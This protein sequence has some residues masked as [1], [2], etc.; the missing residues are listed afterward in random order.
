MLYNTSLKRS[1]L[2]PTQKSD[3]YIWSGYFKL[4][5]YLFWCKSDCLCYYL[6]TKLLVSPTSWFLVIFPTG[7]YVWNY[8]FLLQY[9]LLSN[10]WDFCSQDNV[11]DY[12]EVEWSNYL[13][14]A[15]AFHIFIGTQN[16]LAH[17]LQAPPTTTNPTY[18]TWLTKYYSMMTWLLNSLEEKISSSV[19]FLTTAKETWDTLNVMYDNKKNPSRLFEIYERLF[20]LKQKK[21]I[22]AWVL[23]RTQGFEWWARDASTCCYWYDNPK[24][25]SLR[26]SSTKVSIQL[27]S[28][29]TIPGAGHILGGDSNLLKSYAVST[30]ADVFSAPSIEQSVM[31]SGRDRGHGHHC[32]FGGQGRGSIGGGRGSYEGRQSTSEKG[33]RHCRHY[34]YSNHIF[35]KCWEKFGQP[36]WAQLSDSDPPATCDN[37]QISSSAISGSFMI[38][39]S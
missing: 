26:F 31:V 17:L 1:N 2:F 8:K 19:I 39:L 12:G 23:W 4:K 32:D 22:C 18:V 5:N 21:Q 6:V 7:Y 14:W 24:R 10:C 3:L 13:S 36:E 30:G 28:Y 16:K 38:V 27:E 37:P 29:T 25:L 15:Q 35:E 11:R 33:P 9:D 20:D 34:G